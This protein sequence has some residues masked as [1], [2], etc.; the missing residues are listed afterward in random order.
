[1]ER[2]LTSKVQNMPADRSS[3]SKMIF[4]KAFLVCY[5]E[6][7][8]KG[9]LFPAPDYSKWKKPFLPLLPEK[10]SKRPGQRLS[11]ELSAKAWQGRGVTPQECLNFVTKM[12]F[13]RKSLSYYSSTWTANNPYT[14]KGGLQL[15]WSSAPCP[16]P[17]A[18]QEPQSCI[19][20]CSRQH[21][22]EDKHAV[23]SA[24]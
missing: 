1:M 5:W 6:L 19:V 3:T 21:Q 20:P 7:Q 17:C 2:G 11:P 12:K 18:H 23:S 16:L 22:P 24:L 4:S 13:L 10:D 8:Y 14:I 15:P 9:V